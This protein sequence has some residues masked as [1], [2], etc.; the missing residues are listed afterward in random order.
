[1]EWI[2]NH[3]FSSAAGAASTTRAEAP[4]WLGFAAWASPVK[5]AALSLGY[6]IEDRVLGALGAASSRVMKRFAA[7]HRLLQRVNQR[8][9]NAGCQLAARLGCL[10]CF[11]ANELA[12]Q[13]AYT[14]NQRRL[15][16]LTREEGVTS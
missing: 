11:H 12:F 14:L 15:S 13:V 8:S 1:M 7:A 6:V 9:A 2:M 5:P 16:R 3:Y 4:R 10:A